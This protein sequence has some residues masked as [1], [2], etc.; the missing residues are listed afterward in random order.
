VEPSRF[1]RLIDNVIGVGFVQTEGVPIPMAAIVMPGGEPVRYAIGDLA[2]YGLEVYEGD[3]VPASV[4]FER[5]GVK[6]VG[7]VQ[8]NTGNEIAA[9][10]WPDAEP[11][12]YPVIDLAGVGVSIITVPPVVAAVETE[13][14]AP[15]A[16]V[17]AEPAPVVEP[18]APVVEPPAPTPESVAP[19]PDVP[20]AA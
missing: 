12:R 17:I 4:E 13:T 3:E 8:T 6:G 18:A 19:A 7:F 14:P 9:I 11:R 1:R 20:P 5:R 2:G 10:A 16:P 15:E